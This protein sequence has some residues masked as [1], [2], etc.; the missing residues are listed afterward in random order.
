MSLKWTNKSVLAFVG[1]DEPVSTLS[2]TVRERIIGEIDKGWNG[3]PYDPFELAERWG[4]TAS[5]NDEVR[6]ARIVK[7]GATGFRIEFNPSRSRQRVRYSIAHEIAHTFFPD[8]A[9]EARNRAAGQERGLGD[10]WQLE[11]LCNIAAAEIL[12]PVGSLPAIGEDETNLE[13]FLDLGKRYDVSTEAIFIRLVQVASHPCAMF[14]GSR[15]Q[16]P[17]AKL[18]YRV[19]YMIGSRAWPASVATKDLPI[20]SV[21]SHCTSI[22]F[23]AKGDEVWQ[24]A[25]ERVHLECIAIPPYPGSAFP[26]VVGVSTPI[27]AQWSDRSPILYVTGDA[28]EPQGAEPK[29]IVHVVNDKTPNWGGHGFA[30]ALARKHPD[31][32]SG[33][34]TWA[35][36]R[37]LGASLGEVQLEK[38]TNSLF[39]ASM[40][41]Q[42]GYGPSATPRIRYSALRKCLDRVASIALQ[43]G[44]TIHMPQIGCGEA[45]GSWD[46]IEELIHSALSASG[47]AVTVYSL[48][49]RKLPRRTQRALD[50]FTP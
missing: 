21:A 25:G 48:P 20:E 28:T 46:I 43:R 10:E 22:G 31:A 29:I 3:P 18:G 33:F 13:Y 19:D 38:L 12:M 42:H 1:G 47:V 39:V 24:P 44:A 7:A 37:S 4:I 49:N 45:G 14:C 17:R 36:K 26:R 9:D 35:E 50:L 5:P 27:G 32:Q 23:S 30:K 8:C 11:A 15:A 34:R 40:V 2:R 16:G 6:D 41:S